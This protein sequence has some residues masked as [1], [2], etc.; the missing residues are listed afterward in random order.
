MTFDVEKSVEAQR[1]LCEEKGYPHFAPRF[2]TCYNCRSNIYEEKEQMRTDFLGEKKTYS[3][4]IATEKAA[5]QLITGC[6]HCNRS[7]CD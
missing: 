4:G 5:S 3:T 1:Q 6:P 2:G 7:Y